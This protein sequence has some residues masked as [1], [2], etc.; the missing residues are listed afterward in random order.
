MRNVM[1]AFAMLL[2][3]GCSVLDVD[4]QRGYANNIGWTTGTAFTTADV[5]IITQRTHPVLGNQIV[6]TEPSPDVAKALSTAAA[7]S[8]QGSSGT[9]SG[10]VG[11]SGGSAEAVA[12]LAGRSTALMG[13]RDGL[14]RACEAYANGAIGQDA[15]ALVL[16]RYGELMT[17]L[18]LGQDITGAAGAEG[19]AAATSAALQQLGSQ[20]SSGTNKTP[21][22]TT[23]TTTQA[24]SAAKSADATGLN[25]SPKLLLAAD[26]VPA[27]AAPAPAAPGPATAAK[28]TNPSGSTASN[29]GPTAQTS[30]A[31]GVSAAAALTLGRMNEDYFNLNGNPVHLLLVACISENDKTRLRTPLTPGGYPPDTENAWL[32]AICNQLNLDKIM[33]L[34]QQTL[35]VAAKA[36]PSIKPE[37]AATQLS[38]TS[39]AKQ[40]AT[41]TLGSAVDATVVAV[42]LALQRQNCAGCNPGEADG[43]VGKQTTAAVLAYQK[44]SGLTPNGNPKDPKTMENLGV[45][46]ADARGE[47]AGA[48][49]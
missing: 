6:C 15:Y 31:V 17:T 37:V 29:A 7:L 33:T 8:A 47:R 45:K 38:N 48:A 23:T 49:I 10:S 1:I 9:A 46:A 14:Y 13:L 42:Q 26:V 27:P 16:S 43:I 22:T 24:A 30:S 34:E 39:D 12:E 3:C 36:Y 25:L 44:A 18:F 20:Q 28:G 2:L 40:T 41:K 4:V 35:D 11:A 21:A 5:R 32:K 19:K